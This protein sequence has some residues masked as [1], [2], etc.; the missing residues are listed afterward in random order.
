MPFHPAYRPSTSTA[1]QPPPPI[2]HHPPSHEVHT[3]VSDPSGAGG[4]GRAGG[5]GGKGGRYSP[6]PSRRV[7]SDAVAFMR[8]RVH[9]PPRSAA[10]L[11]RSP[12]S[13]PPVAPLPSPSP[14]LPPPASSTVGSR[15]QGGP[16][17]VLLPP[18]LPP[19]VP[20]SSAPSAALLPA[21]LAFLPTSHPGPIP[22]PTPP[23]RP[24]TPSPHKPPLIIA[25]THLTH[26]PLLPPTTLCGPSRCSS[27]PPL[28]PAAATRCRSPPRPTRPVHCC[29]ASIRASMR[30]SFVSGGELMRYESA[31]ASSSGEHAPQP[32][33]TTSPKNPKP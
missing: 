6:A 16:P 22:P 18:G 28:H 13:P 17:P 21:R 7:R 11:P 20:P 25:A 3:W 8:R 1:P 9:P 2:A 30:N 24:P 10:L 15:P 31:P 23:P 19:D 12:S 5:D 27:P 32:A 29:E 14:P 33:M 26:P 4:V